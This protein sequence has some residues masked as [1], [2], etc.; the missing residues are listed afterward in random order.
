[1]YKISGLGFVRGGSVNFGAGGTLGLG[2]DLT[3][4]G[5]GGD[6]PAEVEI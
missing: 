6:G 1:M 3:G 4:G 5:D 2:V